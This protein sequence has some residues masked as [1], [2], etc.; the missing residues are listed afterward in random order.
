VTLVDIHSR[1]INPPAATWPAWTDNHYWEVS[2]DERAA[3]EAAEVERLTDLHDA[4]AVLAAD[5]DDFAAWLSQADD[6][7]PVRRQVS[8]IELSMLAAHGAI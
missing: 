5:R 4:P 1:P 6:D 8:P 3:L 2:D 7:A